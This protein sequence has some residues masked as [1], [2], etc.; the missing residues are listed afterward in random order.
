MSQSRTPEEVFDKIEQDA[1][2][3][4]TQD[5]REHRRWVKVQLAAA[6]E[7]YPFVRDKTSADYI[8]YH[9]R[10]DASEIEAANAGPPPSSKE[11]WNAAYASDPF[12]RKSSSEPDAPQNIF[13]SG[14]L[15]L[16]TLGKVYGHTTLKLLPRIGA[17]PTSE[18]PDEDPA[19][20]F[21]ATDSGAISYP[22]G[23]PPAAIP[24]SQSPVPKHHPPSPTPYPAPAP[25]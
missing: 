13:T 16:I 17:L 6:Q 7:Q 5:P 3:Y 22:D 12:D 15:G 11:F 24:P 9:V 18:M 4:E 21:A 25:A 1:G 20:D 23:P 14:R 2:R 10:K 19:F 8:H